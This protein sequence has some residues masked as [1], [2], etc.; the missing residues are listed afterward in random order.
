ME[1]KNPVFTPQVLEMPDFGS[2]RWLLVKDE[3][4]FAAADACRILGLSNPTVALAPLDSDERAKFNLGHPF[5]EINFVNEP[6]LYRLIF[7][8][9]KPDAKKFQRKLIEEL[10]TLKTATRQQQ[11]VATPLKLAFV[12]KDEVAWF[13]A[14]WVARELGFVQTQEKFSPTSGGKTYKSV[15]WERVNEYLREFGYDKTVGKSDYLPENMVYRLAM[16]A[17][18]ESAV[19]FQMKIANEIL[20]SIRRTGSYSVAQPPAD[21][22]AVKMASV[23]AFLM[24]NTLV[25]VGFSGNVKKRKEKFAGVKRTYSSPEVAL[26]EARD[27]E[28]RVKEK[29][30][31]HKVEGEFFNIEFEDAVAE[32]KRY[33]PAEPD[34]KLLID[35]LNVPI[36]CPEKITLFKEAANL[37]LGKDIF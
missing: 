6:G 28:R 29:F 1:N 31:T 36:D 32:I 7:Q 24:A 11:P 26:N 18:N 5:Y 4:W 37:L 3:I 9:R 21:K 13:N 20:P 25:K 14:E 15:R 35:L 27:I 17:N 23:Y 2:M 22:P 19:K 30:F 16:K 12:D 34:V 8:S 33:F 10:V